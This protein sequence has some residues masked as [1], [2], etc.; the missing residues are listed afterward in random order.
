[1][2]ASTAPFLGV[3]AYFPHHG[4]IQTAWFMVSTPPNMGKGK[5]AILKKTHQ[6]MQIKQTTNS[7]K[8]S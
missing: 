4:H 1:M 5:V 2:K 3:N 6:V 7:H 8:R